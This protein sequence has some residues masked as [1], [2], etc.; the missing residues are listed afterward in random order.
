MEEPEVHFA[1]RKLSYQLLHDS[2]CNDRKKLLQ[3]HNLLWRQFSRE[4]HRPALRSWPANL[5]FSIQERQPVHDFPKNMRRL[6]ELDLSPI[7]PGFC[8]T[9]REI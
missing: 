6:I 5:E 3:R 4:E 9:P 2:L 7:L 8:Y 1:R